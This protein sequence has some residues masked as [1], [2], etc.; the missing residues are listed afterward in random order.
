MDRNIVPIPKT[1]KYSRLKENINIF[2]FELTPE[3]IQT[4]N[5]FETH[6][7]YTFPSFWQTHPYYPF[8]KIENPIADPFVKTP[9]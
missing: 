9:K 4:I 6:K 5:K 3:E 2:D 1:V 7:R 8:E